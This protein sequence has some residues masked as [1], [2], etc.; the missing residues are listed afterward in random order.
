MILI[1]HIENLHNLLKVYTDKSFSIGFVPTMGALHPGHLS[2]IEASRA[3]HPITVCSIFI[4]PTQFN[5]PIDFQKY[6]V[7]IEEDIRLLES[8][9]C[10]ILFLP[11]TA[12]MYPPGDAI[13]NFE[14]GYIE[15][16]L[17][18]AHR[19]GHFQGVC[20]IVD[21]LLLLVKPHTIYL[22]RK[23]YQQC[24]VI[25]KLISLEGHLT[26]VSVC[27]TLRE[28]GGLAMSSRNMRLNEQEKLAATLL[29]AT[30]QNMKASLSMHNP[31]DVQ[32]TAVENLTDH[33]FEVD[34]AE[35]ADIHT[36]KSV[37]D[38]QPDQIVVGLVAAS[39]GGVRLIDN[40]LL[41]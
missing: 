12:E 13:K 33:G 11:S 34:Y 21:K 9:G 35:I 31:A 17:E 23:D 14:L 38:F 27:E 25:R 30:L 3:E 5:N 4:N 39:I 15:S 41:N 6:P 16:V 29:Y 22:G 36:L 20:R 28:P 40:L 7:T 26:N 32:R 37:K 24:M 18:G 8:T 19:P 1:K 10:D 2:L